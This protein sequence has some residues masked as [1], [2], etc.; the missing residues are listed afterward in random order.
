MS[1]GAVDFET[2]EWTNPLFAAMTFDD[3]DGVRR[4]LWDHDATHVNGKAL[5]LR[6]LHRMAAV[7]RECGVDQWW[8]HN[9]G[10]FDWLFFVNAARE[11]LW[12]VQ[13]FTTGDG[14]AVSLTFKEPGTGTKVQC[15]DSFAV[16]QA[17]LS[18]I[19]KDFGLKAKS[20]KEHDYEKDMRLLP[21]EELKAGCI[22]DTEIVL[23]ALDKVETFA[24]SFGGKLKATAAAM[25]LSILKANLKEAGIKLPDFTGLQ[26]FNARAKWAYYGGRVEVFHHWPHWLLSEWDISSSYPASMCQRLPW[27]FIGSNQNL[28]SAI[29]VLAGHDGRGHRLE[30]VLKARVKV[31]KRWEIPPLPWKEDEES[32]MFFPTGE[33]EAWFPAPL[34]RYAKKLGVEVEPLEALAYTSEPSPFAD[35]VEQLYQDKQKSTGARRAFDK[36]VLNSGYGKFGEKPEKTQLYVC[37]TMEESHA[38]RNPVGPTWKP[39]ALPLSEDLRVLEKPFRRWPKQTHY[40]LASYIT[41]YSQIR[42]HKVLMQAK[43]LA[44]TDTDSAHASSD[45]DLSAFVGSG[46]G[47]LE[48][49]RKNERGWFF[50]PKTNARWDQDDDSVH[51]ASKGVPLDPKRVREFIELVKGNAVPMGRIQTL[52]TQLQLP[53]AEVKRIE[54]ARRWL[55]ASN[56]RKPFPDGRTRPWSIEELVGGEHLDAQSPLFRHIEDDL[57]DAICRQEQ[58]NKAA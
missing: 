39:K 22:R 51:F 1:R 20:F 7:T 57:Q 35:L 47:Q 56:K 4:T 31:S 44:M 6:N 41:A 16:I 45:S 25:S 42:I 43:G 10:K 50:A 9:A 21:L 15:Y 53:D 30:G 27:H 34:L 3:G 12:R 2:W 40:A 33:W 46:L 5:A 24:E 17:K 29:A 36:I 37:D 14:R 11:N 32:A 54:S 38:L 49:K 26:M 8:G 18:T 58:R 23:E 13:G 48:L 55:G 19:A 52:R 28:S